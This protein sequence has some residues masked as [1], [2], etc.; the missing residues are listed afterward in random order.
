[1]RSDGTLSQVMQYLLPSK[2]IKLWPATEPL[3][4]VYI[5]L[6]RNIESVETAAQTVHKNDASSN[7]KVLLLNMMLAILLDSY[8]GVKSQTSS[9]T[10]L[11]TQI[12]E[13]LRRRASDALEDAFLALGA[14]STWSFKAKEDGKNTFSR[15]LFLKRQAKHSWKRPEIPMHSVNI[16][17]PFKGSC[18]SNYHAFTNQLAVE[19][20][21]SQTVSHHIQP[22]SNLLGLKFACL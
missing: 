4:I 6:W 21:H 2:R 8:S 20:S 7:A 13:M 5:S 1:M 14:G 9:M 3:Q 17:W 15:G 19:L 12:S 18:G 11:N 16:H 22:T 10:T